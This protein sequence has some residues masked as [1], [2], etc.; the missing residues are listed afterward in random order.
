VHR[1]RTR[2]SPSKARRAVFSV[3]PIPTANQSIPYG[4]FRFRLRPSTRLWRRNFGPSE[5]RRHILLTQRNPL[6]CVLLSMHSFRS[7]FS[8]VLFFRSLSYSAG[9]AIR[10]RSR[11]TDDKG[12]RSL[13]WSATSL[14]SLSCRLA[15]AIPAPPFK[16]HV[17]RRRVEETVRA[18]WPTKTSSSTRLA[19][20]WERALGAKPRPNVL[21]EAHL[22]TGLPRGPM[23]P[24]KREGT[25]LKAPGICDDTRGLAALIA[26]IRALQKQKFRR[27]ER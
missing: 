20:W 27:P 2:R 10:P 14:K 13:P 7:R 8:Q 18:V 24:S 9:P 3:R 23:S 19:T 26:T 6:G 25:L 15:C 11:T 17:R 5:F 16:E 12:G 21:I 1:V 4:F 22:D